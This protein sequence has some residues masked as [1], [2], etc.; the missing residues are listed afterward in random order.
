[1]QLGSIVECINDDYGFMTQFIIMFGIEAPKRG[2]IYVIREFDDKF[3]GIRLE[4]IVND[5]FDF[6]SRR[7][8]PS[9]NINRFR[10]LMPPMKR[11]LL[12]ELKLEETILELA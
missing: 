6:A 11:E 3:P 8:E 4:E 7:V 1:M 5:D 2:E 10:E 12:E 9:F